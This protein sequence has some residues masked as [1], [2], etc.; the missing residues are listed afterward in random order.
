MGD[1][2]PVR[3]LPY[4]PAPPRRRTTGRTDGSIRPSDRN[5]T[6][7]ALALKGAS[8]DGKRTL[9]RKPLRAIYR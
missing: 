6:K 1:L 2:D 3:E 5:L 7:S 4:G 8:T 9:R